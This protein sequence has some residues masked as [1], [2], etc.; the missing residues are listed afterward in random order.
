M[1]RPGFYEGVLVAVVASVTG[2]VLYGVMT[3]FFSV[4]FS[5][6]AMVTMICTAYLFYLLWHSPKKSGRITAVFVWFMSLFGVWL[7]DP[8]FVVYL[9]LLVGVLWLIRSLAFYR[10]ITS[11]LVD[12]GLSG[13][14]LL[15]GLWAFLTSGSLLL[16]LWTLFLVQALFALIPLQW[17][18]SIQS[19]LAGR[20]DSFMH[21]HRNAEAALRKLSLS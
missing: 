9:M 13:F 7:L 2:A 17:S 1:K 3:M 19:N 21:A 18:R 4:A 10:S 6:R 14:G 12:L 15:A 20:D 16:G 5:A 11:A 8:P